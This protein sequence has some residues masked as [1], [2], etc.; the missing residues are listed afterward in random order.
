MVPGQVLKSGLHPVTGSDFEPS[1]RFS[2]PDALEMDGERCLRL[3]RLSDSCC[4]NFC[5]PCQMPSDSLVVGSGQDS[6]R[7]QMS[8][9]SRGLGSLEN[10]LG[11]AVV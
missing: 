11:G 9:G 5:P 2:S 4:L 7:R 6:F 10:A 1:R 3:H 8:L